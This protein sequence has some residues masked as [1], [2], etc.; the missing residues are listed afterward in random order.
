M[1]E[2]TDYAVFEFLNQGNQCYQINSMRKGVSLMQHVKETEMMSG[3]EFYHLIYGMAEQL[4]LFYKS[5]GKNSVSCYGYVNPLAFIIAEKGDIYLLDVSAKESADLVK[6]MQ[7]R[8]FRNLFVRKEQVLTQT[9]ER[10]DDL[11][12]FGKSIQFLWTQGK[13]QDKFSRIEE[14]YIRQMIEK[15]LTEKNTADCLAWVEKES[16]RLQKGKEKARKSGTGKRKLNI[17]RKIFL[18]LGL[19]GVIAGIGVGNRRTV[20]SCARISVEKEWMKK[21]INTA[22]LQ[23]VQSKLSMMK[24]KGT[25]DTL[26]DNI[27]ACLKEYQKLREQIQEKE[28]KAEEIKGLLTKYHIEIDEDEKISDT[29]SDTDSEGVMTEESEESKEMLLETP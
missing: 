12:G 19:I 2:L 6:R 26:V 27:D 29:D 22:N 5:E 10:E 1:T 25:K 24:V 4:R 17:L 7:K 15:C 28:K 3:M 16:G 9:M 20:Q 18:I 13:F 8:D 14:W 21:R 11:Y 23:R